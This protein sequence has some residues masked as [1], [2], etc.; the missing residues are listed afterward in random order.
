MKRLNNLQSKSNDKSIAIA[1][2]TIVFFMVHSAYAQV[3]G[4]TNAQK[5]LDSFKKQLDM[6]I[7]IAAALILLCLAIGYAGRYIEKDTF[8]RWAIGVV[9]AGSATQIATMLF[10]AT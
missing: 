5:V 6:I 8:I 1:V 3:G 2:A 7:P 4:L 10:K 9:I